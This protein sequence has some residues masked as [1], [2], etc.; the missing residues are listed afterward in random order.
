MKTF[1]QELMEHIEILNLLAMNEDDEFEAKQM[2]KMIVELTKE[3]NEV[4]K[5][6]IN[7]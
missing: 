1:E 7:C 6:E 5:N 4:T 3:V 2:R